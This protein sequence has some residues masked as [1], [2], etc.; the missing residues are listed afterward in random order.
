MK[1]K[2]LLL[3]K[4]I[5]LAFYSN[6]QNLIARHSSGV[7]TF[8]TTLT[9]AYTA[10]INDDTLYLPGGAFEAP[11]QFI[12]KLH[13]I[14]AGSKI[15]SSMATGYTK[16]FTTGTEVKINT[17]ASFS[18]FEGIYFDDPLTIGSSTALDD[19]LHDII[20]KQC[21][22]NQ[23]FKFGTVVPT[24]INK[25]SLI[26]CEV[27]LI[28]LQKAND[29][30][31]Y[32]SIFLSEVQQPANSI[33]KN[34]ILLFNAQYC[35]NCIFENCILNY[36]GFAVGNTDTYT[37]YLNCIVGICCSG[38]TNNFINTLTCFPLFLAAG[39][40]Y[41][42]SPDCVGINGGTDGTDVGIYGGVFVWKDG[43]IPSNPHISSKSIP[44]ASNVDG[45]LDVNI[46][47]GAQE[48]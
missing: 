44:D 36:A 6:S 16:I 38:A 8:Y 1:T 39:T 11:S 7:V 2:L 12:K 45:T 48:N 25:I 15:D 4:V 41:N 42:L 27:G 9:A 31:F 43:M 26:N 30:A 3:S 13:L 33:F 37:T 28:Q 18:S 20:F 14:G 5:L 29:C 19:N 21:D 47:V 23:V 10:S 34:C 40:N 35:D 46:K 17:G 32:N 22:F 24:P